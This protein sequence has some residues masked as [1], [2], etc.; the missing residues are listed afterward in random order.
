ML[1]PGKKTERKN[2][3]GTGQSD[4]FVCVCEQEDISLS[5]ALTLKKKKKK[6]CYNACRHLAGEW[7]ICRTGRVNWNILTKNVGKID[8]P[9]L[10]H[11]MFFNI[12]KR[13]HF[14]FIRKLFSEFSISFFIGI[15]VPCK[16]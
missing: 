4:L 1:A 12:D 13:I 14:N 7:Q 2:R 10:L 5:L 15:F 9:S 11:V 3:E 16:S 6:R 8:F